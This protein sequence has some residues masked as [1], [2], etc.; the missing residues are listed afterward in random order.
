MTS[1]GLVKKALKCRFFSVHTGNSV[2]DKRFCDSVRDSAIAEIDWHY[3]NLMKFPALT[4]LNLIRM[5]NVMAEM[6]PT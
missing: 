6:T 1:R 3:M 4:A 5:C 2:S